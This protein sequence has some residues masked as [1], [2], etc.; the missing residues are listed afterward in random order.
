[1]FLPYY[2]R[3]PKHIRFLVMLK[4]EKNLRI[5]F[6]SGSQ[7]TF[8][9]EKARNQLNL[10]TVSKQS[11]SVKSFG[12]NENM[13]KLDREQ[14]C[15][16]GTNGE[17]LYASA[18]VS[19]ICL[20]LNSQKIEVAKQKY[21]H[22]KEIKLA[23]SN[24]YNSDLEVDILIDGDFYWNFICDSFVRGDSGPIALLTKIGYVLSGPT[25]EVTDSVGSNLI[26][27][28]VMKI[29]SSI[30]SENENLQ[31]TMKTFWANETLGVEL[32][33][34]DVLKNLTMRLISLQPGVKLNCPIKRTMKYLGI[35]LSHANKV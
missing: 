15:I 7:M 29:Q 9:S 8:I 20:S 21:D 35:I 13:K 10:K 33:E 34:N 5:L 27:S 17:N 24:P 30:L 18:Y 22:L 2:C 1:M 32:L 31:S 14:F 19:N 3:P 4:M 16:K 23:D 26:N 11:I 12:N 28:H 6:D 25:G